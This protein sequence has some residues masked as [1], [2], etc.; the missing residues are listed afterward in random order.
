MRL[1]FS[2]CP[3]L[4]KHVSAPTCHGNLTLIMWI[5]IH[6]PTSRLPPETC[7]DHNH[8]IVGRIMLFFLSHC[9]LFDL[10]SEWS[11]ER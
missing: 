8:I 6:T 7:T 11:S 3:S 2:F 10:G 4:N 1:Q 5:A 9:A